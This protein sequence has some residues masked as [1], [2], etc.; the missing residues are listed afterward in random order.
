MPPALRPI[1]VELA[2][3]QLIAGTRQ[4][5]KRALL[6]RLEAGEDVIVDCSRTRYLDSTGLGMLVTVGKAFFSGGGQLV[7]TGLNEDIR[8]LFELTRLDTVLTTCRDVAAARTLIAD[9]AA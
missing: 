4:A 7:L 2:P 9:R 5:F 1:V 8:L 3:D 6:T